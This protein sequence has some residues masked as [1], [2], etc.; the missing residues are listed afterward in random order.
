MKKVKM[1]T[2]VFAIILV[3]IVAVLGIYIPKQNRMENIV[4]EYS[5]GMDL[6]GGRVITLKP[7]T[8]NKTVIKDSEGKEVENAS[9]LSDEEL[10]AKGY[11]KEEVAYN[12]SDV[13]TEENYE[14]SKK[15]LEER[16]KSLNIENYEIR[17]DK[18][19]GNMTITIP[20]NDSTDNI[21]SNLGTTGKFE[22]VDSDTNEV[23]MNNEDIKKSNVMYGSNSSS[24]AT[25][26]SGTIVYLNIEFTK[27]GAKKLED[28]SGKYTNT[29]ENT[30]NTTTN[31]E[32]NEEDNNTTTDSTS[33]TAKKITMKID[34]ETIMSTSF[35]ETLKTGKLQLSVGSSSTD[36]KTIQ[37][38]IAQAQSM[39]TVLDSGNM[40][41][42]YS[43]DENQYVL[44]D[45]TKNDINTVF[46]VMSGIVAIALV[47]LVIKYKT[48]G[49]LGAISYIGLAAIFSLIL[50]YTNVVIT[51]EGIAGIAITLIMSYI[52]INKLLAKLKGKELN[53]TIINSAI[54]ETYKEFFIAI[55]PIIIASITFCFISWEPISSFGMVMFWGIVLIA[56][57][58]I[59]ISNLLLKLKASNK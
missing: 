38:Y 40:P 39:A 34:D 6:K 56:A 52:F 8:S 10:T 33:S 58:N 14:K 44:S 30:T 2:I 24:S 46:Y 31:T 53:K 11:T 15:I 32:T 5:Y 21:V 22:I 12:S 48:Q 17:L 9:S 20:E 16:F 41:I 49:L 27:D 37:G 57:Y 19:S 26:S 50:R 51:I 42:K 54:K 35:D 36:T 4:K 18:Q 28:I 43:V 29:T 23:L 47:V 3:T 7:D 13:L 25:S 45:I 55:I 59:S 1:L